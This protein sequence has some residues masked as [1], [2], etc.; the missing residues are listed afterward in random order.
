VLRKS[1]LGTVV[2]AALVAGFLFLRRPAPAPPSSPYVAQLESPVRG[3]SAQEVR[4]LLA[5]AG[6][7]YA[8]TAELNGYPGP[9]H[10]LEMRAAL[11][12]TPD[13]VR[14]TDAT[15]AAME[16]EAKRLGAEIVERERALAARFADHAVGTQDLAT[17]VDSLAQLYG[18]LR[19][20]HLAAH[21]ATTALLTDAQIARYNTL[22]GYGAEHRHGTD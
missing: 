2:I 11:D 21:L 5:G 4:D 22:R 6:A 20:T 13:Q 18:R 8:R 10:V 12:L 16:T 1:L 3:L 14:R 15:F 9:R 19:T 17:A 7:G